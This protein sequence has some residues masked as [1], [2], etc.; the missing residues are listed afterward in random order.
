MTR[1]EFDNTQDAV[2]LPFLGDPIPT[3]GWV[4]KWE[5]YFIVSGMDI[6][7]QVKYTTT[8]A[9][10]TTA[11]VTPPSPPPTTTQ[12]IIIITLVSLVIVIAASVR[13]TVFDIIQTFLCSEYSVFSEV[14]D[15]MS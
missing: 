8:T 7:M 15:K 6:A 9:T 14:G 13:L 11:L 10:T 12:Q 2:F 5:V 3:D 1:T 4:V